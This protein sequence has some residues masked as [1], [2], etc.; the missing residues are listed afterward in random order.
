MSAK[1]LFFPT[2]GVPQSDAFGTRAWQVCARFDPL[3]SRASSRFEYACGSAD[4]LAFVSAH[5]GVGQ[6]DVFAAAPPSPQWRSSPAGG[7]SPSHALGVGQPAAVSSAASGNGIVATFP[8]LLRSS[9][10]FMLSG[11]IFAA[12]GVGHPEDPLPDVVRAR[13]VCAQYRLPD[14]VHLI[15]HVCAK[16]VE[17]SVPNRSFNLLSNNAHRA[18][19]P[20]E[21]EFRC[22]HLTN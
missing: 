11:E 20:D 2:R 14:G 13:A 5:C 1:P 3:F 16:T 12:Q 4:R 18:A 19:L 22:A 8:S 10:F 17:P 9:H 21:P 6:P 15:F 7:L